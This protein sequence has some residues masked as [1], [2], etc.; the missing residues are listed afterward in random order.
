MKNAT[1]F[2]ARR[3]TVWLIHNDTLDGVANPLK[4]IDNTGQVWPELRA[5]LEQLNPDRVVL[6]TH[7][8][9]AFAGGL[10]VGELT[11]LERELGTA[12]MKKTVNE[13]MLA[14]E[15]ISTKVSGQIE[16]YRKMQE[17]AWALVEEGF[18]HKA[19][20]PGVTTTE[21]NA[22]RFVRCSSF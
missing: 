16:Y 11:V 5:T 6:N 2:A 1:D 21:V 17:T 9:I 8:D 4:W 18:S 3:R 20:E 13:P 10:H 12:W 22:Y 19:I 7:E 15:Y 14:V